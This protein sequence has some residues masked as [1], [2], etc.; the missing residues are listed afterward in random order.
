MSAG[1]PPDTPAS[2]ILIGGPSGVGKSRLA[3]A[4]ARRTASTVAQVDDL[5]TAIETLVP[6]ERLPEYHVP[7]TTYLRTRSPEEI[8]RAIEQLAV[9]FS[10][11][12]R[13]V[14]ENRLES[15]TPTVLEGDFIAPEVAAEARSVGVRSLF[16]LG[17]EDEIQANFLQRD[18]DEQ[19]GRAAVSAMVSRRLAERCGE[20]GLPSTSGRPFTSLLSRAVGMLGLPSL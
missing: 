14:I 13:G 10:P 16:L 2:V 17:T 7:A 3:H 9:F 11:G 4:L 15:G 1:H 8:A 19:V 5:Q 20:L 6:S 18:G 12:V